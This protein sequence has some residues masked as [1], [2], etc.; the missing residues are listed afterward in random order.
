M[1]FYLRFSV[2]SRWEKAGKPV[3]F[4]SYEEADAAAEKLTEELEFA[5]WPD[6]DDPRNKE[7]S[8]SQPLESIEI[9]SKAGEPDANES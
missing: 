9:I 5:F 3:E 2:N 7:D 8:L 4:D 1:K 6:S